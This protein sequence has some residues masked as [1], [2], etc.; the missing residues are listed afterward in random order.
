MGIIQFLKNQFPK[1]LLILLL[2]TGLHAAEGA[3]VMRVLGSAQ[4]MR[5]GQVKSLRVNQV[6]LA[7]DV[8]IGNATSKVFLLF[9]DGSTSLVS[10]Q[11]RMEIEKAE[12]NDNFLDRAVEL[13][14]EGVGSLLNNVQKLSKTDSFVIQTQTIVAGVRG[15][16]FELR[17]SGK[18]S[19]TLLYEGL[20]YVRKAGENPGLSAE[21]NE[22]MLQMLSEILLR[23]GRKVDHSEESGFRQRRIRRKEIV[24]IKNQ[25]DDLEAISQTYLSL[26]TEEKKAYWE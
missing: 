23:E 10:G 12:V 26:S 21:N 13:K 20:L 11:I 8:L 6:L 4:I 15:T 7:G 2:L 14:A 24:A 19:T 17:L 18:K 22:R 5:E 9:P 3:R 16:E 1:F 25:L